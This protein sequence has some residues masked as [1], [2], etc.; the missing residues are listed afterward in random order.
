MTKLTETF[1]EEVERENFRLFLQ[2]FPLSEILQAEYQHP[3]KMGY[4]YDK[5]GR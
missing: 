2:L 3:E 5:Y 1:E 4:L